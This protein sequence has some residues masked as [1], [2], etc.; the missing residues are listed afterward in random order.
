MAQTITKKKTREDY[1]IDVDGTEVARAS[2]NPETNSARISAEL[3]DGKLVVKDM[4][5]AQCEEAATLLAK[6]AKKAQQAV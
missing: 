2:L 1:I 5:A 3:G 4:D 6:I